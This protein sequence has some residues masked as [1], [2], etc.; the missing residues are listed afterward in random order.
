MMQVVK[1]GLGYRYK[2]IAI[3]PQSAPS[4][5]YLL[6]PVSALLSFLWFCMTRWSN[7]HFMKLAKLYGHAGIC[8]SRCTF[9]LQI[10]IFLTSN[11]CWV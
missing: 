5:N 8:P 2:W 9:F 11:W 1:P 6:E 3:T 4:D 7:I 10:F